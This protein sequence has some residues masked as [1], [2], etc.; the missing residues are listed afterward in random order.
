MTVDE[1]RKVVDAMVRQ[2]RLLRNPREEKIALYDALI[3]GLSQV[4]GFQEYRLTSIDSLLDIAIDSHKKAQKA[5][6]SAPMVSG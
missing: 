4:E 3:S 2:I 1:Q 6:L 5:K